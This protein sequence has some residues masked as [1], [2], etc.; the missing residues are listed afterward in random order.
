M[1]SGVPFLLREADSDVE[2]LH[3]ESRFWPG[4]R[5]WLVRAMPIW[6]RVVQLSHS[7]KAGL[8][9][10]ELSDLQQDMDD[11]ALPLTESFHARDLDSTGLTAAAI[12]CAVFDCCHSRMMISLYGP[13]MN[14]PDATKRIRSRRYTLKSARTILAHQVRLHGFSE[15]ATRSSGDAWAHFIYTLFHCHIFNATEYITF[16]LRMSRTE[17]LRQQLR[18]DTPALFD[19]LHLSRTLMDKVLAFSPC[20]VKGRMIS[21]ALVRAV[22]ERLRTPAEIDINT[23]A[24]EP[25]I[26]AMLLAGQESLEKG[27]IAIDEALKIDDPPAA[28]CGDVED[29]AQLPKI[30]EN[31]PAGDLINDFATVSCLVDSAMMWVGRF[32]VDNC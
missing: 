11:L 5:Q 1:Q 28:L 23:P 12:Q 27:K 8:P 9:E 17:E 3:D 25:I 18:L 30:R 16:I 26:R 22:E 24:A 14:D 7:T 19:S 4:Y 13:S 6:A 32:A 2:T 15:D 10:T 29:T 31:D 21:H 20:F